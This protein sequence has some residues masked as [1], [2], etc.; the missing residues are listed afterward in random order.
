[1]G[2]LQMFRDE[3]VR[4]DALWAHV[5]EQRLNPE[6][7]SV[8]LG[9]DSASRVRYILNVDGVGGSSQHTLYSDVLPP[10]ALIRAYVMDVYGEDIS[11]VPD[12][13]C[14]QWSLV[15]GW[16]PFEAANVN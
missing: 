10:A 6:R 7:F 11:H 4:L 1:M 5:P 2:K 16:E 15:N 3:I 8:S 13:Q 12:D 14:H 9:L